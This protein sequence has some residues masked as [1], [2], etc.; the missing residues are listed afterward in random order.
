MTMSH[1]NRGI[2]FPFL[3]YND[4]PFVGPVQGLLQHGMEGSAGLESNESS[5]NLLGGEFLF[6]C[7]QGLTEGRMAPTTIGLFPVFQTNESFVLNGRPDGRER[8]HK[9]NPSV[10][11]EHTFVLTPC[12]RFLVLKPE[13]P[14]EMLGIP[15][16]GPG[17][18][19]RKHA[20]LGSQ[21]LQFLS[22]FLCNIRPNPNTDRNRICFLDRMEKKGCR[23][24]IGTVGCRDNPTF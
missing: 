18:L 17:S 24:D 13:F 23:L 1:T 5:Q 10:H 20:D 2:R 22:V 8:S 6:G 3:A 16:I 14:C 21:G 7:L 15:E 9:F 11:I 4:L 12:C 19:C